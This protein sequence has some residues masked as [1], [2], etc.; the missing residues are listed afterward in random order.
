M[1]FS[2]YLEQELKELMGLKLIRAIVEAWQ[3]P[4]QSFIDMSVGECRRRLDCVVRQ[5]GGHF[6]HMF[7]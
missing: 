2:G 6:E 5:N 4:S 1:E 7:N 3:K